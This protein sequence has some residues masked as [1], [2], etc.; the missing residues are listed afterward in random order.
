MISGVITMSNALALERRARRAYEL[1]RLT[2]AV[3][4]LAAVGLLTAIALL[5]SPAR[6]WMWLTTS[7]LAMTTVGL[8]WHSRVGGDDVMAGMQAGVLPLLMDVS[9]C[10]VLGCPTGTLASSYGALCMAVGALSGI[11][12]GRHA[13]RATAFGPMR[14]IGT[15]AVAA[16]VTALGCADLGLGLN[17]GTLIAMAAG[18]VITKRIAGVASMVA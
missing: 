13:A 17:A 4:V 10:R 6:T 3:R 18:A 8:R 2:V 9:F 7:A 1:G 15:L 12:I 11:W 16:L 5:A 14:W